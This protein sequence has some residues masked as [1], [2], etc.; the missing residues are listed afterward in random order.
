MK[1]IVHIVFTEFYSKGPGS[2]VEWIIRINIHTTRRSVHTRCCYELTNW[3]RKCGMNKRN[4]KRFNAIKCE[5][6]ASSVRT[7][8]CVCVSL[9]FANCYLMYTLLT[10]N[11]F[12]MDNGMNTTH[13]AKCL[14]FTYYYYWILSV[15]ATFTIQ[16]IALYFQPKNERHKH[17]PHQSIEMERRRRATLFSQHRI[18]YRYVRFSTHILLLSFHFFFVVLLFR[19]F[20]N[21]FKLCGFV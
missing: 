10:L 1:W 15:C 6:Q 5:K 13:I 11:R 3:T 14:L 18:S 9:L 21:R 12:V 4:V 2:T 16:K 17:T 7:C 8:V 20:A 19:S